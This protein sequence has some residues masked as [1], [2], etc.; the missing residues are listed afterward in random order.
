MNADYDEHTGHHQVHFP[1]EPA[2]AW[3][4]TSAQTVANHYINLRLDTL[5]RVSETGNQTL[6]FWVKKH[7]VALPFIYK[8]LPSVEM[9]GTDPAPA[10]RAH[11]RTDDREDMP[12][13]KK[14]PSKAQTK[15]TE[16]LKQMRETPL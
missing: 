10:K 8:K 13:P 9:S 1:V 12:P 4:R 5:Q 14:K 7:F 2:D 15:Q 16:L 11:R 6:R 3:F